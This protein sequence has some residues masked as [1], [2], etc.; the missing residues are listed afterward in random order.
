[1]DP[2]EDHVRQLVRRVRRALSRAE[3][4]DLIEVRRGV[5]YRLRVLPRG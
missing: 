2:S 3:M 1:V 5:G 4:G